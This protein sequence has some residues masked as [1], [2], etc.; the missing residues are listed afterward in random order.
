MLVTIPPASEGVPSIYMIKIS[1]DSSPSPPAALYSPS[2]TSQSH[3]AASRTSFP[4]PLTG[5]GTTV[6]NHGAR[7]VSTPSGLPAAH[8][9]C[10]LFSLV[11]RPA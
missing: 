6:G 5:A 9:R 1:A 4:S 2:P 7:S 10:P 3:S 11:A 8:L